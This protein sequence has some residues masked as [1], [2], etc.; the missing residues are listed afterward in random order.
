MDKS[1]DI[2]ENEIKNLSVVSYDTP[3]TI[4]RTIWNT[5]RANVIADPSNKTAAELAFTALR[6]M[7]R[8]VA[9]FDKRFYCRP[10]TDKDD[11]SYKPYDQLTDEDFVVMMEKYM[12]PPRINIRNLLADFL[13]PINEVADF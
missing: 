7:Y 9:I 4:L 1:E 13:H 10:K 11:P 12:P 5:E 3:L 2:T 6:Q 8:S